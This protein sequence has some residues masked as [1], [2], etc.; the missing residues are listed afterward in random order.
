MANTLHD[1]V[2]QAWCRASIPVWR[3][4]LKESI[5]KQDKQREKYAK[6]ML[7]DVLKVP[8]NE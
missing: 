7:T 4:I 3:I 5:A 6:W 8:I 1:I 2:D